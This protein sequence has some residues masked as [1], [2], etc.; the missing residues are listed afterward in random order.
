MV[1]LLESQIQEARLG[2]ACEGGDP[3]LT[4]WAD[5]DR[6]RQIV[7]NLVT[8]AIKFTP[9]GGR[10]EVTCEADEEWVRVR[11]RDT[12]RGVPADMIQKIF[13]PFVQVRDT[14]DRDPSRQGVGLGLAISRDLARAM[15]G[16]LTVE[17]TLGQ[18][19]TFTLS[20]RRWD[21]RSERGDLRSGEDRRGG[22]ER[23]SADPAA[24]SAV[25]A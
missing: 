12:G 14:Q 11:V 19:S 23:R 8:N 20:L 24:D 5:P 16:D 3:S 10:I 13:D 2:Y 18:G 1:A 22:M 21:V 4:A 17:S 25:S 9:A 7:L 6:L 15:G